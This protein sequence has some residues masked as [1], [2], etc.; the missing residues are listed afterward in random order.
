MCDVQ[1]WL[2]FVV[3]LLN[4]FPGMASEIFFKPFV[5]TLVA[6]T[7]TGLIIHL[8]FHIRPLSYSKLFTQNGAL[9]G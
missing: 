1:V 4:I 2:S 3:N 8:M 7:S 9:R 6:P 5:A